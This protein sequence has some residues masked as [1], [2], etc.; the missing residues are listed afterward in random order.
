[1]TANKKELGVSLAFVE[2][3]HCCCDADTACS[4]HMLQ[5]QLVRFAICNDKFSL[6]ST[7]QLCDA[8]SLSNKLKIV[9][10]M[11][12]DTCSTA[13]QLAQVLVQQA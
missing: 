1:M 9:A 5:L 12:A 11:T 7:V 3:G 6:T 13:M 4:Q 2:L 10:C 8:C